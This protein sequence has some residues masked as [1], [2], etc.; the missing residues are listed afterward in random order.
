MSDFNLDNYKNSEDEQIRKWVYTLETTNQKPFRKK[1]IQQQIINRVENYSKWVCPF[2]KKQF[3]SSSQWGK[4]IKSKK[5]KILTGELTEIKCRSCKDM[6]IVGDEL[7]HYKLKAKC[8]KAYIRWSDNE[9]LK[10]KYN[11]WGYL[12]NYYTDFNNQANKWT[13]EL[14]NEMNEYILNQEHN[15][16]E[17][18]TI[19]KNEF[20][21][22]IKIRRP[23]LIVTR[24]PTPPKEEEYYISPEE[25]TEKYVM[26]N[27]AYRQAIEAQKIYENQ[28][29]KLEIYETKKVILT[30]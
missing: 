15:W 16:G 19:E 27:E 1:Q 24:P 11:R 26:N 21:L 10:K 23:E 22:Y 6:L 5:Y 2:T 12:E 18:N 4:Y 29:E 9:R 17:H 3:N 20:G 7:N 25:E 13:A 28:Q 14:L 8:A 30:I